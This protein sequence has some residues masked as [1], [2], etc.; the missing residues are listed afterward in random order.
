MQRLAMKEEKIEDALR[1]C[2][3]KDELIQKQSNDLEDLKRKLAQSQRNAASL[4]D[5]QQCK[6]T[7]IGLRADIEELKVKCNANYDHYERMNE[8]CSELQQRLDI[9]E[10]KYSEMEKKY[11]DKKKD[12]KKLRKDIDDLKRKKSKRKR[13]RRRKSPKSDSESVTDS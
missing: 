4:S 10:K 13:T 6:N 12:N 5:H 8:Q 11:A 9:S 7:E 3:F 1:E 2:R